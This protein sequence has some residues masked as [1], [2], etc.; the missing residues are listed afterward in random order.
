MRVAVLIASV[1]LA[2]TA[3]PQDTELIPKAY[4]VPK[5]VAPTGWAVEHRYRRPR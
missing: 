1:L 4:L 3:W 5:D 2:S